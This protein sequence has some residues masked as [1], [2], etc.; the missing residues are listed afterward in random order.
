MFLAP[1]RLVALSVGFVDEICGF[2]YSG[3]VDAE[4]LD[5]W[6][7]GMLVKNMYNDLGDISDSSSGAKCCCRLGIETETTHSDGI[8][9]VELPET[10]KNTTLSI[11]STVPS[12]Q[13]FDLYDLYDDKSSLDDRQTRLTSGD[14]GKTDKTGIKL[15]L[16]DVKSIIELIGKDEVQYQSEMDLLSD[17]SDWLLADHS[18]MASA[19]TVLSY[20]R[21]GLLNDVDLLQC[22]HNDHVISNNISGVLR[23]VAYQRSVKCGF[24]LGIREFSP[25]QRVYLESIGKNYV[26]TSR[27]TPK[28]TIFKQT[29][30]QQLIMQLRK[31]AAVIIQRAFLTRRKNLVNRLFTLATTVIQ[32][33]WRA[34][35]NRSRYI[36]VH[37][38]AVRIQ[39]VWRGHVTRKEVMVMHLAALII[40][41]RWRGYVC[42]E[43]FLLE[44]EAAIVV[45]CAW[46]RH[47]MSCTASPCLC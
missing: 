6:L 3:G 47:C 15:K 25:R 32:S 8:S 43:R 46:R 2:L 38:A 39:S 34:Y 17:V 5:D 45:Q 24:S 20:V 26:M 27:M 11:Y 30:E 19:S 31:W 1:I 16:T 21:F 13:D 7:N 44:R 33:S 10:P 37:E 22:F 9:T 36:Q 29:D 28:S 12:L 42:R 23:G 18:H 4:Y 14:E 40:Q 35:R 41:S